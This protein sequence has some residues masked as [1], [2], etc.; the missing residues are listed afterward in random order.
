V[1]VCG[2]LAGDELATALL[3]GL[4]VR[5]LSMAAPA[6]ATVKDAVRS[7]TV[8]AARAIAARALTY[9]TAAEVRDLLGSA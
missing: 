9:A 2:E 4:G 7:T 3:L 6:I 1:G 8:A 5:E